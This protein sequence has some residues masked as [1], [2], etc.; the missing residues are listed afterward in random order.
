MS[1]LKE[2]LAKY[3]GKNKIAQSPEDIQ[4]FLDNHQKQ[5][6]KDS[7]QMQE[8]AE[9]DFYDKLMEESD[10]IVKGK[11]FSNFTTKEAWQK[12]N[13]NN[14]M[15]FANDQFNPDGKRALILCGE[16]GAGKTHLAGA[17]INHIVSKQKR[18]YRT[19]LAKQWPNVLTSIWQGTE[20]YTRDQ[21]MKKLARVDMLLLDEICASEVNMG[22]KERQL[23]GE[24][25]RMRANNNKTTI[26]TSNFDYRTLSMDIGSFG[27]GGLRESKLIVI[28][29]AKGQGRDQRPLPTLYTDEEAPPDIPDEY[30][31]RY[32]DTLY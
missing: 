26:L 16:Y 28:E 12:K 1:N 17:I 15:H 32:K 27:M 11:T 22:D 10:V 13:A 30:P 19:F 3:A 2:R 25:L 18:Y 31:G 4:K 24:I 29:I 7:M 23:L 20:T 14:C 8:K 21:Y 9:Q 5:G 6:E